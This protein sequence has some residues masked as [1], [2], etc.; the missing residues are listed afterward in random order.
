LLET[1]GVVVVQEHEVMLRDA[2]EIEEQQRREAAEK[3]RIDKVLGLWAR[4]TKVLLARDRVR[5]IFEAS[6]LKSSDNAAKQTDTLNGGQ[7]K[8]HVLPSSHHH[9]FEKRCVDEV[10]GLWRNTCACGYFIEFEQL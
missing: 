9:A 8:K 7:L 3:K 2:W 1:Q 4:L 10:K 6:S 5:E